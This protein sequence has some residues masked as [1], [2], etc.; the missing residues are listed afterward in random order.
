MVTAFLELA[1]EESPVLRHE[2]MFA[3]TKPRYSF[4]YALGAAPVK[5]PLGPLPMMELTPICPEGHR[6]EPKHPAP[7]KHACD[8]CGCTYPASDTD[9][10]LVQT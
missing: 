6:G 4:N 8:E 10:A 1:G 3:E 2:L 7:A 5:D 9:S